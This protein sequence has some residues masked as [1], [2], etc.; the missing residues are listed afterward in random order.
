MDYVEAH[1]T[2]TALGDPD[3]A[4]GPRGAL[5]RDRGD[6][7]RLVR[8]LGQDQHRAPRGRGGHRR[9]DQGR[10][11]AA[12][13]RDSAAPPLQHAEPARGRRR[14]AR[15]SSRP[16]ACP[17]RRHADRGWRGS[18]PSASAGR[19]RTSSWKS[20]PSR[21][22]SPRARTER[23]LHCSR[24]PLGPSRALRELAR[25]TE[26]HLDAEPGRRPRR[27][28]LHRERRVA[29]TS[30]HRLAVSRP[31][32]PGRRA[33]A[34]FARRRY[35]ARSARRA[36]WRAARLKVAFL[37][38]GQGSQYEGMGRRLYETQPDVPERARSVRRDPARHAAG[39]AAVGPVPG[40]GH[41]PRLSTRPTYAQP[42]LFAL[43]YALAELWRS[44]GVEPALV[45]GPQRRRVRRRLRRRRLQPS[46][47]AC[48]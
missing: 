47:T 28:L 25:R 42:A 36:R 9:P 45:A 46:R 11:G 40:A 18:A 20:R 8:R 24:C 17:G 5:G 38:T 44:W 33:L 30:R 31:P 15:C 3:R 12:A 7:E 22:R 34:A 19:M 37:F 26:R 14:A 4:G 1:G 48:A 43:E 41:S 13:R 10:P 39:A 35:G 16:A 21:R 6:A 29:R 2:G 23:P 27:R 32:A